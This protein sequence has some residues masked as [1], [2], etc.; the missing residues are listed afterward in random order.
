VNR[1]L[2]V[3]H[4]VVDGGGSSSASS[5]GYGSVQQ[6]ADRM[7][8]Q[9]AAKSASQS[10]SPTNASSSSAGNANTAEHQFMENVAL[11]KKYDELVAFSVTLTSE[12]D[13]LNN[14]L[15]QAKRDLHKEM[16]ARIHAEESTPPPPKINSQQ[17]QVKTSAADAGA[18]SKKYSFFQLLVLV[19]ISFFLGKFV[20]G[21]TS[22]KV[23]LNMMDGRGEM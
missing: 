23:G 3:I 8:E 2:Q 4:T 13:I 10:T 1:K 16:T 12:R 6:S 7:R 19:I 9:M 17:G 22:M 14:A 20:N 11:K 15:E 18:Q 21:S 5:S